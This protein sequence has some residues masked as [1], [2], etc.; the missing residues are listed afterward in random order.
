[1]DKNTVIGL[2]LIFLLFIGFS[3]LNAPTE[4][5][6]AAAEKRRKEIRDSL[7]QL[8]I[9]RTNQEKEDIKLKET[10]TLLTANDSL[11]N[12][13]V[14][15]A[16][17]EQM[18]GVFA[19]TAQGENQFIELEN[20][21]IKIIF[22]TKG[23]KPYAVELKDYK[24]Y[25]STQVQLFDGDD[26]AFG[27]KFYAQNR[28][29]NTNQLFFT[30]D[31]R[32]KVVVEEDG[33]AKSVSFKLKI[34][35]NKYIEHLYTLEPDA[36]MMKFDVALKGMDGIFA[37]NV[38]YIDFVW[39]IDAPGQEKGRQWETDN[40]TIFYKFLKEEVDYLSERSE[41]NEETFSTRLKWIAFKQQFFSSVLIADEYLSNVKVKYTRNEVS[42]DYIM[43]FLTELSLPVKNLNQEK[44]GLQLY[45]GP[46][47]HKILKQYGLK[48]D[49]LIPLGWGIFGWVNMFIVI[50]LFNLLGTMFSSY[51]LIILIMTVMIKIALFPLTYK[52][53][54]STAKMRVLKP[55]VEKINKKFPKQEDAMKK[56]QAV[57][58]LY[59]KVGVNPMGGC[60]PML[61]QMPI[62]FAMF[63]FFPASIELRQ[64][65]FLWAEDLSTYD[66]I[67]DLPFS[68]PFYGDHVSLFC[69][70]MAISMLVTTKM[71]SNQMD[72]S[73]S[74]MPGMKMM[75][76]MMP[77]MMLF[78][79]NS[80]SSGLSYY[81][82]LSNIIT[83]F[84]TI[85]IRRYVDDDEILKKLE[86][87]KK[88]PVK[89]SK[90]QQR[91]EEM[92]KQKGYQPP[93]GK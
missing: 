38:N 24:R 54:F 44:I 63:R 7:E 48:L 30:T 84:Q 9:A 53:Y 13:S 23:G 49:K 36:Y 3:I 10:R 27:F 72:T 12:D 2:T 8:Q 68:I 83:F 20:S 47:R 88:K 73:S 77:V 75:M 46:N 22:S 74:Q 87:N 61:L 17:M 64:K 14:Q 50:P 70:L 18:Y 56:Q 40:T 79:F 4:E 60:L 19:K 28:L 43:N 25:D 57:M 32:P 34:D 33:G 52:S 86:Q 85:L 42:E 82:L 90:F 5:Q 55:E 29:I 93:K 15:H 16:G 21:K 91:L 59:K 41:E 58:A 35:E 1:M 69:L 81:Y 45:F 76:Y 67:L 51:G 78:F 62:L 26:N 92:A 89:K 31:S 6:R 66:S 65:S 37:S 11:R 71:N 39:Q 80:Y